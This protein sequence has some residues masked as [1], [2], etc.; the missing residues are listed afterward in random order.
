MIPDAQH[1]ANARKI[2]DMVI[3]EID[4][5]MRVDEGWVS[6]GRYRVVLD[7]VDEVRQG[8]WICKALE[9]EDEWQMKMAILGSHKDMLSGAEQVDIDSEHVIK[10]IE[11]LIFGS[12][13]E[14]VIMAIQESWSDKDAS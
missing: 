9:S 10:S 8:F 5:S 12:N 6:A 4:L 7:D 2:D 1:I 14:D 11:F 13:D 3:R